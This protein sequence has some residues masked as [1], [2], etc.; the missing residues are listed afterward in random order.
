[1]NSAADVAKK[2][3]HEAHVVAVPAEAFGTKEHIRISY[4]VS[5]DE[6]D[7]GL[8]RMKKFLSAL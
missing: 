2:L 3:L 1:M 4:A 8:D 5:R 7:K 6:I